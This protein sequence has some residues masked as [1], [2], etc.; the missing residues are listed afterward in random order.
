MGAITIRGI[1]FNVYSNDH[2][3]PHVDVEIG[4]L[5]MKIQFG[6]ETQPPEITKMNPRIKANEAR[7]AFAIFC[8]S[9]QELKDLYEGVQDA[10][11]GR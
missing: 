1:R 4:G 10:K 11:K 7:K 2:D 6:S 3:P 8:E 9:E 5:K